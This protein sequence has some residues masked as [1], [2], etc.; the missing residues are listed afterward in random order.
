MERKVYQSIGS[1]RLLNIEVILDDEKTLYTGKVEEAPDWIKQL[2]YSD[3]KVG[4][5]MKYFVYSECNQEIL[6]NMMFN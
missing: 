2:K 6:Q 4:G 3:V 1:G 5:L